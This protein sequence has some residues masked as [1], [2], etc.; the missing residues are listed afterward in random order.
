M[1]NDIIFR[2]SA[3]DTKVIEVAL[4]VASQV[5][6]RKDMSEKYSELQNIIHSQ[7]QKKLGE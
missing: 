3:E 7:L 2:F 6:N 1:N 5:T 4:K